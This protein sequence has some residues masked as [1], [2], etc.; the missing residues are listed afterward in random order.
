MAR[1]GKKKKQCG[2]GAIC[3][4]LANYVHPSNLVNEQ[5]KGTTRGH[6]TGDYY[7]QEK[8]ETC[9]MIKQR[10]WRFMS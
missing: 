1:Q 8:E 3:S 10:M 4:M 5:F 9:G 7:C 6:Q 2:A